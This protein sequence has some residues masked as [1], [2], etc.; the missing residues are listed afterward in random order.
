MNLLWYR[1]DL[2]IHSHRALQQALERD[3]PVIAVYFLCDQQWDSHDVAPL[4]RWY[5]LQSLLELGE[6]LAERGV[7]LHVLDA[8]DF[9]AV[10]ALMADFVREHGIERLFCSRE[11]PLNE[12]NRD[13][14]VAQAME[15]LGVQITGFDDS[16][17]V[18]PRTLNTGKGTPYTV[19]SA[20][21]KRWDVWLDSHFEPVATL[22]AARAGNGRFVGK[23]VVERALKKLTV[24]D[25]LT[26]HWQPGEAAALKQLDDFTEHHLAG[27]RKHRDFPS[28]PATSALS[29]ALSAGTLSPAS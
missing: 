1:N 9:A 23:G 13:R 14:A 22:P 3:E 17:L 15:P 18:P 19:F 20:F 21:K 25:F 10:P 27:Y 29:A 2:R 16:V 26:R 11:Y 28:Q 12:L 6:A 8:G 24:P 7:D 5:V 4:R